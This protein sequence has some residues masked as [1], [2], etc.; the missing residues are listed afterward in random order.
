MFFRKFSVPELEFQ[1]YYFQAT[2]RKFLFFYL[3]G[4]K[5]TKYQI[6]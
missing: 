3:L 4:I 6:I 5:L 1:K 2:L